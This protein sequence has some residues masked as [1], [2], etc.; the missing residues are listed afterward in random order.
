MSLNDT[1]YAFIGFGE[2]RSNQLRRKNV[3]LHKWMNRFQQKEKHTH[4][5]LKTDF[6]G[7]FLSD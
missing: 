6:D 4:P 2:N 1:K 7:V 3:C 5:T